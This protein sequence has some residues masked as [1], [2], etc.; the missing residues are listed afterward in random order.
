[1]NGQK[2]TLQQYMYDN[3]RRKMLSEEYRLLTTLYAHCRWSPGRQKTVL[4]DLIATDEAIRRYE[5]LP[6]NRGD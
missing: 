1:M 5:E 2:Y 3:W 6:T 4:T